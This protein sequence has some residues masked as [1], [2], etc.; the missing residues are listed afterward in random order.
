M[1]RGLFYLPAGGR[2]PCRICRKECGKSTNCDEEM[3]CYISFG[4][5]ND[6][7]PNFAAKGHKKV[8]FNEPRLA[9]MTVASFLRAPNTMKH[10]LRCHGFGKTWRSLRCF[11]DA[12]SLATA[13]QNR[14]SPQGVTATIAASFVAR[15]ANTESIGFAPLRAIDDSGS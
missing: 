2:F 1:H 6:R 12:S 9:R 5:N 7:P 11:W 13:G 14:A 3:I 15:L 8:A 4:G 10:T